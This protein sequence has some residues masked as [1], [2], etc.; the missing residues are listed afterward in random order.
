MIIKVNDN[1]VFAD[2]Y[3]PGSFDSFGIM[4][5]NSTWKRQLKDCDDAIIIE[6]IIPDGD[7]T[8]F[9]KP[10]FYGLKI[11]FM[12]RLYFD[13]KCVSVFS[14]IND[15]KFIVDDFLIKLAGLTAFL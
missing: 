15:A 3:Q 11:G 10:H 9:W 12:N 14:N 7:T 6:Y 5:K 8:G 13:C 2:W 1:L 4:Y